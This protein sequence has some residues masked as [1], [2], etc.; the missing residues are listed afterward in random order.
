MFHGLFGLPENQCEKLLGH[1]P[2]L[3][4][5]SQL[6]LQASFGEQECFKTQPL[7]AAEEDFYHVLCSQGEGVGDTAMSPSGGQILPQNP[8]ELLG[9]PVRSVGWADRFQSNRK[10]IIPVS[11]PQYMDTLGGGRLYPGR[12]WLLP[13]RFPPLFFP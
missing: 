7:A 3:L 10:E 2:F 11:V 6:T 12:D 8:E 13:L 4:A 9:L 1:L 5:P